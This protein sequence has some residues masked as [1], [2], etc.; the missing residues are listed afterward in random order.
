LFNEE[1]E[2]EISSVAMSI[3]G[4]VLPCTEVLPAKTWTREQSKKCRDAKTEKRDG[5]K[6]SSG[7]P[8]NSKQQRWLCVSHTKHRQAI[9]M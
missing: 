4:L 7:I 2:R 1:A 3:I 8:G 6:M 9:P 5:A